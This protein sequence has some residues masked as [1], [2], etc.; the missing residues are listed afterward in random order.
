L[1][2]SDLDIALVAIEVRGG[3]LKEPLLYNISINGGKAEQSLALPA[4]GGYELSIRGH[5]RYGELKYEGSSFLKGVEVGPSG[6]LDAELAPVGEDGKPIAVSLDVVGEE[7][8]P[9]GYRLVIRADRKELLDGETA[10][11]HAFVLDP[12]GGEIEIDPNE[13][14]WAINDP[15][16][17]RLLP[18]PER[19]DDPSF[20]AH[21]LQFENRAELQAA[22]RQYREALYM[23]ILENSYVQVS[24]GSMVTCGLRAS[25]SLYCWGSNMRSMLGSTTATGMCGPW[26]CTD[27]PILV[28][29]GRKYSSVS[30]G[31]M[32]VCAIQANTGFAFCW[33]EDG[34]TGRLGTGATDD[35]MGHAIANAT[36]VG[37]ASAAV[38][39]SISAGLDHTCGVTT[40]DDLFC[41]GK[42]R[43]GQLDASV[44]AANAAQPFPT[45][46]SGTTKF[47]AVSA[48][49]MHT[50]GLTTANAM[51]CWGKLGGGGFSGTTVM[52]SWN[53]VAQSTT[54]FHICGLN[55]SN[56]GLCWG[57]GVSGQLGN[58]TSGAGTRSAT[59]VTVSG[60]LNFSQISAGEVH[61]CG[62]SGGQAV[63][64]GA[65]LYGQLGD[66]SQVQ[67]ATPVSVSGGRAYDQISAGSAH[68]CAVSAGDVYCWGN[69]ETGQLGLGTMSLTI[70]TG[71]TV[72]FGVK[73]PMKVVSP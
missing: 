64:W 20:N 33:G 60:S 42:N 62:L 4:G 11:L 29:G 23:E 53:A 43:N 56:G 26:A 40:S 45:Q 27:R 63:C 24:A 58:G 9:D 46:V 54:A 55:G 16:L 13:I 68:T 38:F 36:P 57:D 59:P 52:G 48:G 73:E 2:I 28:A 30:V 39:K 22:W 51:V 32:H 6:S 66:Y 1:S 18:S 25:G 69:N 15:R 72:V 37:V 5:D 3:D 41:W 7:R 50:C 34:L 44:A 49:M 65:N 47:A 12:K 8:A 21:W 67:R 70:G 19:R 71:S 31:V 10:R 61:S 14:H 35:G 17:G